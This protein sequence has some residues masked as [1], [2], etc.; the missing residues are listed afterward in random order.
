MVIFYEPVSSAIRHIQRKGRTGRLE[1]GA[2]KILV[3]K[4]PLMRLI[5]GLR[6]TKRKNVF[7]LV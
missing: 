5:A 6:F 1:K 2:V 4:E 7:C 3:T